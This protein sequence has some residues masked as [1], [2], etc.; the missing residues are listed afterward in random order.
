MTSRTRKILFFTFLLLFAVGTP[1][2]ILYSQGYYFDFDKKTFSK[3]GAIFLKTNPVKAKIFINGEFEKETGWLSGDFLIKN[4]KVKEYSVKA[5]KDGFQSWQK[6]L[7]VEPG[8]VTEAKHVLLVPLEPPQE[9]IADEE[10]FPADSK[11][12][13]PEIKDA[14]AVGT[15]ENSVYYLDSKNGQLW[16]TDANQEKKEQVTFSPVPSFETTPDWPKNFSYRLII[17]PKQKIAVIENPSTSLGASPSTS[18]G[19]SPSTSLGASG[20]LYLLNEQNRSFQ[21]LAE[22]ARSAE[23]S[24]DEQKLLYSSEN[25]LWVYFLSDILGQPQKKSGELNLITR[26]SQKI[27]QVS[28]LSDSEH[29][30]FSIPAESENIIKIAELDDRD[31]RNTVDFIKIK[32]PEFR[33]DSKTDEIYFSENKNFYG[34]SLK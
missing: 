21:K 19:A 6:T 20:N 33:Y 8:L 34:V 26:L 12:T 30:I 17:S 13:P 14:L 31:Q 2:I 27:G 22:R 1:L 32:S 3:T 24:P 5:E 25:E 4:L 29:V 9:T 15:I 11:K 7:K 28:W 16:R 10:A 23:F 18:L